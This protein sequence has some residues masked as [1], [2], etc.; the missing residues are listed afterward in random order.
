[1]VRFVRCGRGMWGGGAGHEGR[2]NRFHR[3]YILQPLEK[4]L[5]I[6]MASFS[7]N[8]YR[9]PSPNVLHSRVTFS[10]WPWSFLSLIC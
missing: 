6:D 7:T 5:I 4:L 2:R 1:V 9:Q 3:V 10:A 8:D